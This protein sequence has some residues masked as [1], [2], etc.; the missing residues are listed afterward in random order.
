[1]ATAFVTGANGFIGRHL[2]EL[3]LSRGDRVIGLVRTTSDTSPLGPLFDEHGDRL[4]LVVGDLRDPASLEGGLDGVDYV[5]HL[6]G[7]LLGTRESEFRDA[8]V[9]GTSNLLDAAQAL[10]DCNPKRF[11]YTS[12]LAA[13]GPSPDGEPLNEQAECRPV[14]WYGTAKRDA[15]ELVRARDDR[16]PITIVRPVAVYGEGELELARGTFPIVRAGFQPRVGVKQSRASFVYVGDLVRGMVA[17]AESPEARGRTYFLSD[18]KPYTTREIGAGIADAMRQKVRI[19]LITPVLALQAGAVV[20]E[21]L[22]QFT[23]ERPMTTRDK[24]RELRHKTWMGSPA[25]A[26]RDFD[27]ETEMPL[28]EGLARQVTDWDAK[29]KREREMPGLP[30]GDRA[31]M[32]YTLAVLV[33]IV[34]ESLARL[35]RWYEFT[36]HW[37]IFVVIFIVIGG[38]MGTVSFLTV[39]WPTWAQFAAGA[40]VGIGAELL[41]VWLLHAWT[42][43]PD[44]LGAIPGDV[45]RAIVV[46]LPAG[47]MP[48]GVNAIVRA[49][50]RRRLRLG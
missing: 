48:V 46:G 9:N 1:M 8:I 12:S 10:T 45:V 15:E 50:Y 11:V 14:S 21:W 33:G 49:L 36:P 20:S 2:I 34:L 32:T 5:F 42:F 17:A 41:N 7:V 47:L 4:R 35:G 38:I 28:G 29:R 24:V 43:N 44:S 39:R 18:S 19:P 25:A 40:A 16:L 13:A 30:R 22:H 3:L 26:K 37:L 27:W 23:R 6:G 31:I